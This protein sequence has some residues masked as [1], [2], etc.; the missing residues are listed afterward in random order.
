[1]NAAGMA[2]H[3]RHGIPAVAVRRAWM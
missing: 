3:Y 1:L 2:R